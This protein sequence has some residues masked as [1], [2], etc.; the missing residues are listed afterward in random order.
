M[1]IL[2]QKSHRKVREMASVSRKVLRRQ[3]GMTVLGKQVLAGWFYPVAT[4]D[5]ISPE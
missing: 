3:A 4:N 1:G 5:R 2:H